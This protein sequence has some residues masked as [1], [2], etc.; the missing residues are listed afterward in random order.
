MKAII[1]D[2]FE[3]L[4]TEWGRPKI[5]SQEIAEILD[6]DHQLFR[7][8]W[9]NLQSDFYLGKLSATTIAYQI[10]LEKLNISRKKNY[11]MR[12]QKKELN[13]KINVFK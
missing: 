2:L 1:F 7:K 10:I 5:T 6:I 4:I 3:T 8:E 13:V 9:Q 12:Y 11:L